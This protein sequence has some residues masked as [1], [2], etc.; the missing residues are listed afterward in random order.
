VRRSLGGPLTL[1]DAAAA[2]LLLTSRFGH[3]FIE[4]TGCVF[5]AYVLWLRLNVDMRAAMA[6][7]SWTVA[8]HEA[9]FADSAHLSRTFRRMFGIAPAM[10]IIDSVNKDERRGRCRVT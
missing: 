8:A 10:L 3:L 1:G 5:R 7:R 6:G 4:Q 9:G 2:A